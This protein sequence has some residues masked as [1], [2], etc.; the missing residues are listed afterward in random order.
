MESVKPVL[1]TNILLSCDLCFQTHCCVLLS[2]VPAKELTI[3]FFFFN[4]T[5]DSEKL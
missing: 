1:F 2:N 3:P 4:K 5:H